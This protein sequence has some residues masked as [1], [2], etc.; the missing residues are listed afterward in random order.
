MEK[1]PSKLSSQAKSVSSQPR[2][3]MPTVIHERG[4]PSL[5]SV[6]AGSSAH[7]VASRNS[8]KAEVTLPEVEPAQ[9]EAEEVVAEGEPGEEREDEV[10]E[11][12]AGDDVVGHLQPLEVEGEAGAGSGG[13]PERLCA[14]WP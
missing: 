1:S 14:G 12:A 13:L 8:T 10:D 9:A 3:V 7:A 6:K 11:G 4:K 2:A 5:R